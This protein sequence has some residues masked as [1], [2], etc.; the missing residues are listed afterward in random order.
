MS[1]N[2][3]HDKVV[4]ITGG[5][6]GI[7][8]ALALTIGRQKPATVVVADI[9]YPNA[10]HVA[11]MIQLQGGNS[12]AAQI[13]VSQS[14]AV[15]ELVA[16]TAQKYGRLDYIFNNAGIAISGEAQDMTL[17]HWHNLLNVSLWGVINGTHAAYPIMLKQGF[18]HIVNTASAAGLV[19]TP[20]GL[21]YTTA[22]HAVVGL[23]TSLRMEAAAK[24]VKVSVVCPGV[25]RTPIFDKS[26][27]VTPFDRTQW[28]NNPMYRMMEPE[29]CAHHILKGVAGNKGIITVTAETK[30]MWW[31]YRLSPTLMD[32]MG[33]LISRKF[34]EMIVDPTGN[35][36]MKTAVDSDSA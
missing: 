5:A 15:N 6:S 28:L 16:N 13:D 31:L 3:F 12:E 11:Q 30:I 21:P 26:E 33:R 10:Q 7:G 19:P 1:S 35:N 2:I 22:K 29:V 32:A 34:R 14:T 17:D 24:G 9:D 36:G 23:S 8:Q 27:D 20:M 25:I 4:I 18:G